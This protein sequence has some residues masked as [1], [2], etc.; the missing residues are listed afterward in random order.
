[1]LPVVSEQARETL[2]ASVGRDLEAWK[3]SMIAQIKDENP[4][5]NSLLLTLA[6]NSPD[7]KAVIMAGYMV[8]KALELAYAEEGQSLRELEISDD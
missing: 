7:P 8:Y 5:I 3:K 4:E 1:M 2:E 6:Q